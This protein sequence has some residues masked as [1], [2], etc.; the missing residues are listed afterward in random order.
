MTVSVANLSAQYFKFGPIPSV[1]GS[2]LNNV[3]DLQSPFVIS[4]KRFQM[5]LIH[6][7]AYGC[8]QTNFVG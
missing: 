3:A 1:P 6:S 5:I 8:D 4:V 7:I 2:A